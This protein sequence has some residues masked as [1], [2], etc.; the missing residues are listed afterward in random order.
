MG[1]E[2]PKGRNGSQVAYLFPGQGSQSVGMG[3][4]LYQSSPAARAVFEEVD[5]ALGYPLTRLILEGP[6][7]ELKQTVNT[8]PAIMA[9]SLACVKAMEEALG[10]KE[11]PTPD[12]L[13][14]HSV[15][16]YTALAV[17]RV[18]NIS[19]TALLVRER[20]R[21]M[22]EACEQRPG[23]MAAIL[24]LDELTVEEVCRETGT[25]ISNVNLDTQIVISGERRA[26]AMALDLASARGARKVI[27]LQVSGAFHS[28]LMEPAKEGLIKVVSTL[29]FRD[30]QIPIVS[31]V[32]GKPLASAESLKEELVAQVCSCVQWKR[33]IDYIS[34]CGVSNFI[35]LGP[36]RVLSNLVRHMNQDA[37]VVT[38]GDM[39]SIL[40]LAN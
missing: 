20:G 31:N 29:S 10:S 34:E 12:Y 3:R 8:Q 27:P 16:E 33:S 30:P 15:G 24:G 7:E 25:Y 35:E 19:E 40:S 2:S 11:C 4:D 37:R 23:G 26:L 36:G 17:A 6:E 18:L 22:Q 38:V 5:Q 28:G 9:V 13:A 32:T 39:P 1:L 21:L 14:G